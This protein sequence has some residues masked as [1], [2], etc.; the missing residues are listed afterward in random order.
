MLVMWM[1][2]VDENDGKSV[3]NDDANRLG[4]TEL[5]FPY[6]EIVVAVVAFLMYFL[7]ARL[8]G[9]GDD[10]KQ[11]LKHKSLV[12]AIHLAH[13]PSLCNCCS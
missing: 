10:L 8:T 1:N 11:L 5:A 12:E 3:R 4:K 6:P 13:I 7:V 9:V 2:A